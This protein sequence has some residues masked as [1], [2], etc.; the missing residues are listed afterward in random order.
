MYK[1]LFVIA[2]S[3]IL[4]SCTPAK[5]DGFR[6]IAESV[7][8]TENII[9][10]YDVNVQSAI[11]SRNFD[12][13][14]LVSQ[15][16]F[17]SSKEQLKKLETIKLPIEQ[18]ELRNAAIAYIVALQDIIRSGQEYE[19]INDSLTEKDAEELDTQMRH[20]A[21]NAKFEY[22]KYINVLNHLSAIKYIK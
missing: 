12:Y 1:Y 8:A 13:I 6:E 20:S 16:A 5:R 18:I 7:E 2:S 10:Q 3:F 15:S 21:E 17:D 4:L 22:Q 14:K 9:S 19:A 11:E